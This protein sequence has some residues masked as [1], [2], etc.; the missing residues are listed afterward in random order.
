MWAK[1]KPSSGTSANRSQGVF[2]INTTIDPNDTSAFQDLTSA[3]LESAIE[4]RNDQRPNITQNDVTM[5]N[6]NSTFVYPTQDHKTIEAAECQD[7]NNVAWKEFSHIRGLWQANRGMVTRISGY[8]K[9]HVD[10]MASE[11]GS[12][13]DI[14]KAEEYSSQLQMKTEEIIAQLK[15]MA[16]LCPQITANCEQRSSEAFKENLETYQAFT[17]AAATFRENLGVSVPVNQGAAP[18]RPKPDESLR[19]EKLTAQSTPAELDIWVREFTTYYQSCRLH[20]A[21]IAEQ[22]AYLHKCLDDQLKRTLCRETIAETMIFGANGCIEK[23][24]KE[25][26]RLYPIFAR[27]KAF[28]SMTPEKGENFRDFRLRLKDT[29]ETA[30][31]QTLTVNDLV[32]YKY[33]TTVNDDHL[34]HA[35][36]GMSGASLAEVDAYIDQFYEHE[37]G[38]MLTRSE[39]VYRAHQKTE[40]KEKGGARPKVRNPE[41]V[42]FG[43]GL[44]GH[45]RSMCNAKNTKCRACGTIGHKDTHPACKKKGGQSTRRIQEGDDDDD[46]E[47]YND[48]QANHVRIVRDVSN[49]EGNRI[50]L[51]RKPP[52]DSPEVC[53]ELISECGKVELETTI[54]DT[55]ADASVISANLIHKWGWQVKDVPCTPMYSVTG[56]RMNL[57][58]KISIAMRIRASVEPRDVT[59]NVCTDSKD[60]I[61]VGFT[62]LKRIR[63]LPKNWPHD[64]KELKE[65]AD[66][67][68]GKIRQITSENDFLKAKLINEFSDVINNEISETPCTT[69]KT[70]ITFRDDVEIK[71]RRTAIARRTPVHFEAPAKKLIDNLVKNGIIEKVEGVTQ[72]VSPGFFVPKSN[73]TDVRLVTDYSYLNQ[74]IK[75]PIHPFPSAKEIA[76]RIKPSSKY[77]A[78]LDAVKGYY[79]L[80]LDEESSMLTVFLIPLGKYRYLRNPMGLNISGDEWNEYSDKVIEGIEGADKI[81]DDILVQGD[82][83]QEV[84]E[85]TQKILENCRK[86]GITISEK[87]LVMGKEVDFAGFT[88]NGDGVHPDNKHI[89]AIREF[90]VPK[91]VKDVRSFMGLANQLSSFVPDLAQNCCN[92]K[93]LLEKR[94]AFIWTEIQQREFEQV[95]KLLT[96]NPILKPFD[97]ALPTK[98]LTDASKLHGLGFA[99]IQEGKD[100]TKRLVKCG[101]TGL[102]DTQKRYAVI[103]LE[104]LAVQYALEKCDYF[105]R[106][107]PEIVVMTDHKPL[108]GIWNHELCEVNNPRLLRLRLKTLQYNVKIEWTEGKTHYIAD[109][110]SRYP[111]FNPEAGCKELDNAHVYICRRMAIRT[112]WVALTEACESDKEYGVILECLKDDEFDPTSKNVPEDHPAKVYG[113]QWD[114]MSIILS[115]KKNSELILIDGIKFLVPSTARKFILGEIHKGHPGIV[116]MTNKANETYFWSGMNNDIANFVKLCKECQQLQPSKQ[117]S[118]I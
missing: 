59:F 39:R 71:P 20:L 7:P 34:K 102:D 42:C 36:A 69:K 114:R 16:E 88:I 13:H 48:E 46:A 92:I 73:N 58:G 45:P 15:R 25:F 118:Q 99:L 113:K 85:K 24:K 64:E 29:A 54:L 60:E 115:G 76:E 84:M 23:I 57:I 32:L 79:Q 51:Y 101:S 106:G 11:A 75:R 4:D 89:K 97:I 68:K 41:I 38:H 82:T 98:L 10:N 65:F 77:F 66:G 67:E 103:E 74:F 21:T 62:D 80:P 53:A 83:I 108:K 81:V 100:G 17:T 63:V 28:F 116:R 6:L 70:Q 90:P 47:Q 56:E 111:I 33:H 49:K 3:L 117:K 35:L 8:L 52:K 27:R 91:N 2:S 19:P 94:N 37:R 43:C 95:K 1:G 110:L 96:S 50:L 14:N 78:C 112:P 9:V 22:R 86:L 72:W 26:K 31:L 5:S 104:A 55:G 93:K 105:V 61:I 30:D 44:K 87:K 109:A 40:S 18:T 107:S 12:Q